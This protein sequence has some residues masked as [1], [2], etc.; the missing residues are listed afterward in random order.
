[1]NVINTV[2]N[3]FAYTDSTTSSDVYIANNINNQIQFD[4]LSAYNHYINTDANKHMTAIE[5][6]ELTLSETNDTLPANSNTL[7]LTGTLSQS[8]NI[9][10]VSLMIPIHIDDFT[11]ITSSDS[12]TVS[13][14]RS[15]TRETLFST[16]ISLNKAPVTMYNNA[17]FIKK[18]TNTDGSSIDINIFVKVPYNAK[19]IKASSGPDNSLNAHNANSIMCF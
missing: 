1:M 17:I 18:L 15:D 3:T 13:I 8:C 12:M 7:L 6:Y 19:Y 4:A 14:V 10:I 2:N 16:S 11:Q 5:P 9:A